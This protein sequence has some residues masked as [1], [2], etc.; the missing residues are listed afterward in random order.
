MLDHAFAVFANLTTT[1]DLELLKD[2][3]FKVAECSQS[4]FEPHKRANIKTY[5]NHEQYEQSSIFVEKH[6]LHSGDLQY[7]DWYG[8]VSTTI[9]LLS[10]DNTAYLFE[11]VYDHTQ[12]REPSL[13]D[14][15][16][17]N[18]LLTFDN[19]ALKDARC[20][21]QIIRD[22]N[23]VN[24]VFPQQQRDLNDRGYEW[25]GPATTTSSSSESSNGSELAQRQLALDRHNDIKHWCDIDISHQK[26]KNLNEKEH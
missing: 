7:E 3:L 19:Q 16:I 9:L 25:I 6:L 4:N 20:L 8:T 12:T 2:L 15:E 13:R 26:K 5:K 18:L 23:H 10:N 11:R 1:N 17:G 21:H 22:S 24:N 14:L